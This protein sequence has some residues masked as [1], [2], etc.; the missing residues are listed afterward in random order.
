MALRFFH[1]PDRDAI[2]VTAGYPALGASGVPFHGIASRGLLPWLGRQEDGPRLWQRTAHLLEAPD[3]IELEPEEV[4][5]REAAG[6]AGVL[7]FW[8]SAL[9]AAREVG[10]A[11]DAELWAIKEGQTSSVWVVDADG[12]RFV[13]NVARDRASSKELRR[14]SAR[15]SALAA[16]RPDLPL[17][18]VLAVS[19]HDLDD[20]GGPGA[21]TVTRNALVEDALEIHR[22]PDEGGYALVE[23]F[24]PAE[25]DAPARIGAI[26]GRRVTD[27]ERRQI[28]DAIDAVCGASIDDKQVE[29]EV[30]DGDV[31][32]DGTRAVVVAIS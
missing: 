2:D 10:D 25:P 9:T 5:L 31:V 27:S 28:D 7:A 23:R 12:E 3:D 21:V 15:L 29:L 32:W 8:Q 11:D 17:A 13:V 14:S 16:A 18:P 19:T 1:G 20:L 24:L 22:L 4:A 26:R 6:R 30:N